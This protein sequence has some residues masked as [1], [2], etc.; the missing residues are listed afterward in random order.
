MINL[1][2]KLDKIFEDID[3]CK[4][5]P[6][7]T[8]QINFRNSNLPIPNISENE[9]FKKMAILI[10]F[11]QNAKSDY[12]EKMIKK[13]EFSETFH[14]FDVHSVANMD[15]NVIISESW[16]L[17]KPI[18]FKSKISSIV[19]CAALLNSGQFD[20]PAMLKNI[21][22]TVQTQDDIKKFWENFIILREELKKIKMPFYGNTTSLLHLLLYLGYDCIKPD[23][24]VMKVAINN[25]KIATGKSD[26]DLVKVVTF[27]QEYA[28][29]KHIR[30]AIVDFYLLICAGQ[31]WAKQFVIC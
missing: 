14:N 23:T 25:L 19:K 4:K 11:S 21:P 24:I 22:V 3:K 9:L 26:S 20:L 30:P 7:F 10:C 29:Y 12:V 13:P 15:R 27:I 5:E 28:L 16:E 6:D 1:Y 31:T 8:A 18:R 17:L 2:E